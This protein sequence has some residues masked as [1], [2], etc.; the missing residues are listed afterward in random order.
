VTSQID[1]DDLPPRIAKALEQLAA[2]DELLLVRGGLLVSRLTT[3]KPATTSEAAEPP[4]PADDM[5]EILDQFNAMIHDE[6]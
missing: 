3:A 1:L 4:P 5:E 2:G 6:F